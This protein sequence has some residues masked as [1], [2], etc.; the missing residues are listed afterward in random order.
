MNAAHIM[1]HTKSDI[2]T[3]GDCYRSDTSRRIAPFILSCQIPRKGKKG[4]DRRDQRDRGF[5]RDKLVLSKH[6]GRE[7][8]LKQKFMFWE[9]HCRS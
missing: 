3:S 4:T 5:W 6:F 7:E 2:D 9:Y 1:A 8:A